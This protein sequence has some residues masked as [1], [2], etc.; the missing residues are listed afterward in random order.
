MKVV[1]YMGSP[2]KRGNTNAVLTWVEEELKRLGHEVGRVDIA[3]FE[4]H[5]CI[6][7]YKCQDV[8]DEPGCVFKD[9]DDGEALWNKA[10]A[11]DLILLATPLYCWSFT[12]QLKAFIDRG[13]AV[14]KNFGPVEK[15][16]LLNGKRLALLI[17]AMGPVRGNADLLKPVIES[18]AGYTRT[19][20]TGFLAVPGCTEPT[21]LGEEERETAV[22]FARSI[23][24]K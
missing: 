10:I 20:L 7:C 8:A 16:S 1:A 21:A 14:V 18:F 22:K 3:D 6:S 2:R 9:K 4:V 24:G 5:G 12:A 13:F 11:A 17:T 19:K 23:T 15:K